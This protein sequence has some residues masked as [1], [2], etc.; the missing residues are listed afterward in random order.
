ML[1]CVSHLNEIL[2][3]WWNCWF[4]YYIS[5][6]YYITNFIILKALFCSGSNFLKM[7]LFWPHIWQKYFSILVSYFTK[8]SNCPVKAFV[9]YFYQ[10]FIFSPNDSL[11]KTM[12]N[13]F[14]FHL[15][16]SFR[17]WV[18]QNFVIFSLPFH[19]FQIRR[20]QSKYN[21]L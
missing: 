10:I 17:S 5:Y 14:F 11:L 19:N 9:C 3:E 12:E 2:L 15:K 13:V 8:Y 21:N 16:S 7:V 1:L 4:C 6:K 20:D 18:I